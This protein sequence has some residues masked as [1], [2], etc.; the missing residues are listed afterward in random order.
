MIEPTRTLVI[1]ENTTSSFLCNTFIVQM[2]AQIGHLL[3]PSREHTSERWRYFRRHL[4]LLLELD[5]WIEA[6]V[7]KNTIIGSRRVQ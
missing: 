4:R 6:R 1:R 7:L 5:C 3:S 2:H